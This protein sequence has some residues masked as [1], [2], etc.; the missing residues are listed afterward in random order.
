[1]TAPT[2]RTLP[3]RSSRPATTEHMPALPTTHEMFLDVITAPME[4]SAQL[5][6]D[7]AVSRAGWP[8]GVELL[9]PQ[10]AGS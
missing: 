10:E 4:V 7:V 5:N 9:D 1:M 2:P 3:S 8:L 6:S